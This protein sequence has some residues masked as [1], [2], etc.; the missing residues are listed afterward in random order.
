MINL[1]VHRKNP[2]LSPLS[3]KKNMGKSARILHGSRLA[4]VG[5]RSAPANVWPQ[6][7]LSMAMWVNASHSVASGIYIFRYVC[8]YICVCSV[9]IYIVSYDFL[10]VHLI[11]YS[12]VCVFWFICAFDSVYLCMYLIIYQ[13]RPIISDA[14]LGGFGGKRHLSIYLVLDVNNYVMLYYTI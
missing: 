7:R 5:W 4:A 8:L 10:C 13:Q 11:M 12:F 9:C 3:S 2:M 6:W 1:Y 14:R